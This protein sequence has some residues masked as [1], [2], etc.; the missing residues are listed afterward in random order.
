LQSELKFNFHDY[1][2]YIHTLSPIEIELKLVDN[3]YGKFI[4]IPEEEKDYYHIYF[5]NKGRRT[6]GRI[7]NNDFI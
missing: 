7:I 1:R 5:N 4:N 3:E 2:E 6:E